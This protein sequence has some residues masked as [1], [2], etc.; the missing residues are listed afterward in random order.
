MSRVIFLDK[1]VRSSHGHNLEYCLRV[2]ESFELAGHSTIILGNRRFTGPRPAN[3]IAAVDFDWDKAI[4]GTDRNDRRKKLA[5]ERRDRRR[6]VR[7]ERLASSQIGMA[8]QLLNRWRAGK[9]GAQENGLL[10][11]T[12]ALLGAAAFAVRLMLAILW[13][14][15]SP[16]RMVWRLA[17]AVTR[18]V[19][20]R[21]S[22]WFEP[23]AALIRQRLRPQELVSILRRLRSTDGANDAERERIVRSTGR[24]LRQL[25]LT[26]SDIVVCTTAVEPDLDIYLAILA[27][28]P[29]TRKAHWNF[30]FREPIF[31]N[32]G[33]T[34]LLGDEHRSL[35]T[36]LIGFRSQPDLRTGWWVDTEEL[37]EQYCH[38]GV[39]K[40]G[41]LPIPIPASMGAFASDPTPPDGAPLTI[42]YIG[43][44]R[45][46]KGYGL[47]PEAIQGLNHRW[48]PWLRSLTRSADREIAEESLNA[49]EGVAVDRRRKL[50][51]QR[52]RLMHQI[53]ASRAQ[54]GP[55]D[56]LKGAPQYTL[57]AQSNFNV[58][59]G[60]SVTRAAR[61][62][63]MSQDDLGVSVVGAPQN[64]EGYQAYLRRSDML[65][66]FYVHKLYHAGSS[67][68]FA[69]A[70]VAGR[71]VVL[72]DNSWGGRRL[73]TSSQYVNHL[74]A[75]VA[76][77]SSAAL[78]A[79]KAE[80]RDSQTA[81]RVLPGTTTHIAAL[82]RFKQ[83][84]PSDQLAVIVEFQHAD[85]TLVT[86]RRL[87]SARIGRAGALIARPFAATMFRVRV[88]RLNASLSPDDWSLRVSH[89]DCD[90]FDCPLGAVGQVCDVDEIV[91]ALAEIGRH[92]QHYRRTAREFAGEWTVENRCALIADRILSAAC[93][94]SAIE[95]PGAA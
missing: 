77:H 29:A 74:E 31:M 54:Q 7:R 60:D 64:S 92:Y 47:L 34:F 84:Q 26:P 67:G 32:E 80:I 93:Q 52:L 56:L 8:Y 89:L 22:A 40:F 49:F 10:Q 58:P 38:L 39:F 63:L 20:R 35:R 17:T 9:A 6:I 65:L 51:H 68:I 94:P 78:S 72:N 37:A 16:V 73:R 5:K 79:F 83:L 33:S 12:A 1:L 81:W 43:D 28:Y 25:A 27:Q 75:L 30:I 19:R 91:L 57:L 48:S 11:L 23:R 24:V 13:V 87:L 2:A 46:E 71:P 14:V 55:P 88:D 62:R 36:R 3:L 44:A 76:N 45:R 21:L 85:G 69:E 18:P 82:A 50:V 15:T 4:L 86:R 41:V 90:G 70:M 66:L 53:K 59:G 61:Y 42:G 95:R